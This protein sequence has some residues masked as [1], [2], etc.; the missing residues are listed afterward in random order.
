MLRVLLVEDER[1]FAE[2]L[3]YSLAAQPFA[4]LYAIAA[5]IQEARDIIAKTVPDVV[6]LDLDLPDGSGLEVVDTLLQAG[7]EVSVIVLSASAETFTCADRFAPSIKEVIPK[8]AAYDRLR[9]AI[10]R[11]M[12]PAGIDGADTGFESL[13][14][15]ELEV[16]GMIGEG[17]TSQQI[18]TKL[19]RSVDTITTHRKNIAAKLRVSGAKLVI[20]ARQRNIFLSNPLRATPGGPPH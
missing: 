11:L 1:M 10:L 8:S 13:T 6:V 9:A 16:L 5:S 17:M 3:S 20:L 18:A 2:M 7:H 14:Q 19:T 15:R 12:D 4:D